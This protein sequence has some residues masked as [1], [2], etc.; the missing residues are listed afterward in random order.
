MVQFVY[1][2]QISIRVSSCYFWPD[3]PQMQSTLEEK[4][5]TRQSISVALITKKELENDDIIRYHHLSFRV[6]RF[7]F[8]PDWKWCV[9][10]F[11]TLDI[12]G[13]CIKCCSCFT[14]KPTDEIYVECCLYLRSTHETQDTQGL[15]NTC[16]YASCYRTAE[17]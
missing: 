3:T 14:L 16:V 15:M 1:L 12:N 6:P 9:W 11:V 5:N 4:R 13:W 8:G 7:I 10:S 17:Y 2:T